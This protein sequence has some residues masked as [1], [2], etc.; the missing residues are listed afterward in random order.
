MS[1]ESGRAGAEAWGGGRST[2]GRG[3]GTVFVVVCLLVCLFL[4]SMLQVHFLLAPWD[5][6][7]VNFPTQVSMVSLLS[8]LPILS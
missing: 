7:T 2:G 5:Q 6:K 1:K 4:Q 8:V 3:Q